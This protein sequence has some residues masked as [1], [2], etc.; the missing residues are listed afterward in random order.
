MVTTPEPV[1][2]VVEEGT[3]RREEVE[4]F[5]EGVELMLIFGRKELEEVPSVPLTSS[6]FIPREKEGT[7]MGAEFPT[8]VLVGIAREGMVVIF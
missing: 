6:S 4:G 2:K 3:L 8:Q 1:P 5:L 7:E